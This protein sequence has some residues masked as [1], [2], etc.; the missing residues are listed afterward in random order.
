MNVKRLFFLT[1]AGISAIA[2]WSRYKE[3]RHPNEIAEPVYAELHVKLDIGNRSL[4]QVMLVKTA[5]MTECGRAR[6]E[7][8][9][10]AGVVVANTGK[11]LKVSS[12]DCFR[13]LT[14]RQAGLFEN[15]PADVTYLSMV[16]GTGLE[17]EVRVIVWG[18]SIEES[19]IICD[20]LAKSERPRRQGAV[21]CVRPLQ[22]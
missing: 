1:T 19:N 12:S 13:E 18:I 20:G 16:R 17:R 15:L 21:T 10:G 7:L 3:F 14:P 9:S 8:E 4:E 22:T 5:D 6:S 2:G 11:A